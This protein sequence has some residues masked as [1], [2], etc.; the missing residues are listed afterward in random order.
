MFVT[1]TLLRG[2]M[3][4]ASLPQSF[5]RVATVLSGTLSVSLGA[6]FDEQALVDVPQGRT[7]TIPARK[8]C[9]LWARDGDVLLQVMGN[10][11]PVRVRSTRIVRAARRA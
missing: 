9:V 2:G 4:H 11:E 8:A 6:Q 5:D 1:R 7:W 3:R 10:E